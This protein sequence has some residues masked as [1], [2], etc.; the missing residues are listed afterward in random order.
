MTPDDV[1]LVEPVDLTDEDYLLDVREPVE[2]EAGHADRAVLIPLNELAG[3]LGE[4]PP[5]TVINVICKVGARSAHAAAGLI[6][7]G[8]SCRN[9]AG[10]MLSWE[11]AGLP[12][13]SGTGEDPFVF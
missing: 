8:Y 1:P 12:M 10:G 11:R 2:F 13:V 9:V 3:R 4:L 6:Q 5:D 7:H